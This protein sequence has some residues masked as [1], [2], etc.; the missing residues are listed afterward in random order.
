MIKLESL[1]WGIMNYLASFFL[2]Y[3]EVKLSIDNPIL[4][5]FFIFLIFA[6]LVI[7]TLRKAENDYPFSF[8]PTEQIKGVAIIMIVIHHLYSFVLQSYPELDGISGMLGPSG[9]TTFL[10]LSGFGL[11][12][13]IHK[14][15][16]N[17]FGVA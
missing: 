2:K 14:K 6:S 1:N 13:S 4:L 5:N 16:L 15:G 11:Y 12:L 3:D 8:L 17:K 9:V 10:I 7:I